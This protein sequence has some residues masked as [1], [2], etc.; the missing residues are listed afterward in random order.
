MEKEFVL[1]GRWGVAYRGDLDIF[2]IRNLFK[3]VWRFDIKMEL[4]TL[5][6]EKNRFKFQ[7]SGEGHTFCNVLK[8]EL[9]KDKNIEIAGYSIE[10]SLTAEPV[11]VVEVSSG[12]AKKSVLDAVDRLKKMNKELKANLKSL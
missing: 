6:N 3:W 12:D 8:K 1:C 10:H 4:I 9:W 11:F 5:E 2:S 7:L